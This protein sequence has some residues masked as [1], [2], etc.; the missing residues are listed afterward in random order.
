MTKLI[1][2]ALLCTGAAAG[3]VQPNPPEWPDS[4]KIFRPEDRVLS[5]VNEVS[6]LLTSLE[7]HESFL[8]C[9]DGTKRYCDGYRVC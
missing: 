5:V 8:G 1:L 6:A 7:Q 2:A 4:V 3:R 9:E